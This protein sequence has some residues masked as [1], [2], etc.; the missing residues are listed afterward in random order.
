M[1]KQPISVEGFKRL[2]ERLKALKE[3]ERPAVL[4]AVQKARDLGDLS[5]N[6]DYKTA[7][8]AQRQLDAEIR[9]LE[10]IT[11]SADVINVKELQGD[12]VMFGATV[13]VEDE[14]GMTASYKILS[15]YESDISKNIISITS[16]IARG[17]IGKCKGDTCVIKT[18][19]G[20]KEFEIINV[21]YD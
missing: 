1:N 5:E 16:P 14:E 3:T 18:P 2:Q 15:E 13:K 19:A 17:F 6:A 7:K 4:A 9:R 11:N 12:K 21:K 8:D 10:N 20:E